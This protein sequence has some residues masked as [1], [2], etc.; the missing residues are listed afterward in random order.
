MFNSYFDITRG[1]NFNQQEPLSRTT[2]AVLGVRGVFPVPNGD[3]LDAETLGGRK[4]AASLASKHLAEVV[5]GL[6]RE[7]RR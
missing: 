3:W 4:L 5:P 6:N 2:A 7:G 1:Y